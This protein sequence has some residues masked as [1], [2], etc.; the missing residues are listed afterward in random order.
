MFA[1]GCAV[2]NAPQGPV[3]WKPAPTDAQGRIVLAWLVFN[4]PD[5]TTKETPAVISEKGYATEGV[6][7]A[8][9]P[10]APVAY[11][12]QFAMLLVCRREWGTGYFLFDLEHKTYTGMT[13]P[14]RFLTALEALP[15]RENP[16]WVDTCTA[17]ANSGMSWLNQYRFHKMLKQKGYAYTSDRPSTTICYCKADRI[18]LLETW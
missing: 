7:Q 12:S 13:D 5:G 3:T 17:P 1:A 2:S 10:S 15:T 8:T 11:G 14:R 9:A 16:I 18:R 4:M 6:V